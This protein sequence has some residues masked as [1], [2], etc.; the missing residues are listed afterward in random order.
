MQEVQAGGTLEDL[1]T[2]VNALEE[3][4]VSTA[5]LVPNPWNFNRM[6]PDEFRGVIESLKRFGRVYPCVV[7]DLPGGRYEIIDG[8]HR[9]RA[10][11]QLAMKK[12]KIKSLG[13][14]SDEIA[15]ELTVILNETRGEPD[16]KKLSM[17][18]K[19]FVEKD[20]FENVTIRFPYD[21]AK[22]RDMLIV[23]DTDMSAL[24]KKWQDK[25]QVTG[26]ASVKDKA[27]RCEHDWEEEEAYRCRKCK[28]MVDKPNP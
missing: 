15:K 2:F 11:L 19:E 6:T 10:H 12:I 9:W 21:E 1:K 16:P 8:E 5:K 14:V 18:I 22:L 3:R 17:M 27:G 28:L 25:F 24:Q 20:G 13:K 23:A 4:E 26:A 7:R